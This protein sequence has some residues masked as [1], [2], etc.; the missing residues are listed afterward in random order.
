[1]IFPRSRTYSLCQGSITATDAL[2]TR[3]VIAAPGAG[4]AIIVTKVHLTVHLAAVGGGGV[5]QLEDG[6]GGTAFCVTDADAR[7]TRPQVFDFGVEG[8]ELSENTNLILTVKSA[9]TTQA[10]GSAVVIG[11]IVG[12]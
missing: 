11:Y 12:V 4:K 2:S 1:M 3:I 7:T 9:V 8:Y 5:I 6:A 10:S